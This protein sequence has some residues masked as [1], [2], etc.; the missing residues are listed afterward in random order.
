MT[1][2]K[3][4]TV[5]AVCTAAIRAGLSDT[6]K[7]LLNHNST[8]LNGGE[9]S[10]GG[11][12]PLYTTSPLALIVCNLPVRYITPPARR[13][14]ARLG[15][16]KKVRMESKRSVRHQKF[17]TATLEAGHNNCT[18]CDPPDLKRALHARIPLGHSW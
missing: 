7:S 6:R 5:V 17:S 12:D 9:G 8:V 2:E 15:V 3:P 13:R 14:Q 11:A 10:S 4:T 1:W 16:G 18:F